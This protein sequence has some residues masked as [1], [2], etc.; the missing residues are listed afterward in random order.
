M[1]S[2]GILDEGKF[3]IDKVFKYGKFGTISGCAKLLEI[4][5]K[6][7]KENRILNFNYSA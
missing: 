5:R 2:L 1:Q 3:K 4:I 7:D 6:T